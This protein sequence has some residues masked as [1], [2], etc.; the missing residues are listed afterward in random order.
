MAD[1]GGQTEITRVIQSAK[2]PILT[3]IYFK[4]GIYAKRRSGMNPDSLTYCKSVGQYCRAG[5]RRRR[6]NICLVRVY[7]SQTRKLLSTA[8]PF[9][10]QRSPKGTAGR[11]S[12]DFDAVGRR[13]IWPG[14][15]KTTLTWMALWA[16]ATHRLS[17]PR[18]PAV[19]R[20]PATSWTPQP[21]LSLGSVGLATPL[22]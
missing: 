12:R 14:D 3:G 11:C 16:S 18:A 17:A 19:L 9:G 22:G 1:P 10:S 21:L 13:E 4:P 15:R 5:R 8:P 6:R 7:F 2:L 20:A